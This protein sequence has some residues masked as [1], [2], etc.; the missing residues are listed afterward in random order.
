MKLSKDLLGGLLLIAIGLFGALIL[1]DMPMGD[2]FRLGPAYFPK[3]VSWLI[4]GLGVLLAG[5]ALFRDGELFGT[6]KLRPLLAVLLGFACFAALL[7]IAGLAIAGIALV[8]IGSLADPESRW[9]SALLLGLCLTAFACL[10]F[11]KFLG[12][13]IPLWPTW[14]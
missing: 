6:I 12:L 9:K 10:V 8:L 1:G 3:I 7:R 14:N 13:P 4:C 5:S 2:S 11:S